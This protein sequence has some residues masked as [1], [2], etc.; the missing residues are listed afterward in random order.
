MFAILLKYNVFVIKVATLYTVLTNVI[1]K[2]ANIKKNKY[3][4]DVTS[5][6]GTFKSFSTFKIAGTATSR[7]IGMIARFAT[8]TEVKYSPDFFP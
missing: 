2:F 6:K 7:I 8:K 4:T 3:L 1:I 5:S